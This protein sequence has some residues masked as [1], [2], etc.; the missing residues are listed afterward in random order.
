MRPP[1]AD[2][3]DPAGAGIDIGHQAGGGPGHAPWAVPP[4]RSAPL[5]GL[6]DL[7]DA[8]PGRAETIELWPLSQ[9][10]ID[11]APDGFVDAVFRLDGHISMPLSTLTKRDYVARA[12]RGGYLSFGDR[13]AALRCQLS[14]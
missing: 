9:G 5:L 1:A 4:D 10:E 13:L 14:G 8:L 7:P 12:L 6:K 3:R 2:R 11:S